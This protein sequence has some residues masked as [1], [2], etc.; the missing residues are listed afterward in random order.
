MLLECARDQNF[1]PIS[2]L[3]VA[4][5]IVY[6]SFGFIDRQY[7]YNFTF[8]TTKLQWNDK[9]TVVDKERQTRRV[10]RYRET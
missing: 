2:K 8:T 10:D 3:W 6:F 9:N 7:G 5:R 1:L 4:H